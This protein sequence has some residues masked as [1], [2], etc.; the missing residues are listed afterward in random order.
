MSEWSVNF[1]CT[2]LSL[3]ATV[4]LF[5]GWLT[6][7]FNISWGL[8]LSPFFGAYIA[9]AIQTLMSYIIKD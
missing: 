7:D 5:I 1:I 4:V 2:K 6:G 3:I 9:H 8:C